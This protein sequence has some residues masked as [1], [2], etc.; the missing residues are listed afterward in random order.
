[1]TQSQLSLGPPALPSC[2]KH[3]I[4]SMLLTRSVWASDPRTPPP[5]SWL[6]KPAL[7]VHKALCRRSGGWEGARASALTK[8]GGGGHRQCLA[9]PL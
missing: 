5:Q 4:L 8:V 2:S 9:P 6:P 1:M 7:W 3:Q